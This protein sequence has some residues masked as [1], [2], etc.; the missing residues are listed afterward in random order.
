LRAAEG[1]TYEVLRD[2][3]L[4]GVSGALNYAL[5]A[6]DVASWRFFRRSGRPTL[7]NDVVRFVLQTLTDSVCSGEKL[8]RLEQLRQADPGAG[9]MALETWSQLVES[10][11]ATVASLGYDSDLCDGTLSPRR[12]ATGA[13]TRR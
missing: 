3:F 12:R 8:Q 7:P 13:S 2:D 6:D 5:R 10:A 1:W 4:A 11:R 9:E